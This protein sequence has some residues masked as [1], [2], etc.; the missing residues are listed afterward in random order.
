MHG[1]SGAAQP[2][3]VL[4]RRTPGARLAFGAEVL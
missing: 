4:C 3:Q 2:G 1:R